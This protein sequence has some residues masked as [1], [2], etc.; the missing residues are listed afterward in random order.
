MAFVVAKRWELANA[1]VED[2]KG[3]VVII[4]ASWDLGRLQLGLQLISV[5]KNMASC[6]MIFNILIMVFLIVPKAS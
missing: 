4:K 2:N 3:P 5:N 1:E 6:V